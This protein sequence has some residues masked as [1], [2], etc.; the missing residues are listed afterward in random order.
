M[1][2]ITSFKNYI[3]RV[4]CGLQIPSFSVVGHQ[5]YLLECQIHLAKLLRIKSLNGL[6][7]LLTEMCGRTSV[8]VKVSN[9]LEIKQKCSE[10]RL[11]PA[12]KIFHMLCVT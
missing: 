8:S 11:V 6:P 1:E 2:F 5:L 12:L 7:N 10:F 4:Y 9:L 3:N